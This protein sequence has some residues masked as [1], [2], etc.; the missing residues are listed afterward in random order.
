MGSN[1]VI[2][3]NGK[4]YD[5]VTGAVLGNAHVIPR[6]IMD[7]YAPVRKKRLID[8]FRRRS[9]PKPE[10][11][12]EP[13][14]AQATV[15]EPEP[16]EPAKAEAAESETV[17]KI[18]VKRK[19]KPKPARTVADH[20]K[21][22][23]PQHSKTLLRRHAPKPKFDVKPVVKR[24]RT[25][26]ELAPKQTAQIAHKRSVYS[27]DPI[28]E[29]RAI[30]TT[31]HRAVQHFKPMP[32]HSVSAQVAVLPVEIEPFPVAAAQQAIALPAK[33]HNDIF[34]K[35][36]A[37]ATSHEQ[38][39]PKVRR[40]RKR[41]L[42]HALAV[43][44]VLFVVGGFVG[45]LNL[46]GIQM[47]L[48]SMQAGF[49]ASLP[50]YA[51]TGYTLNGGVERNGDA[52]ALNFRSGDQSYRITQQPSNWNSE[53]LLDNTLGW[54]TEFQTVQKNGQ[55]IYIFSEGDIRA[56]WVNGGVRYEI[57]GN[58]HLSEYDIISIATSL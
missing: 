17:V 11:T 53:T 3:F 50:G 19:P 47:R 15:A 29:R 32:I 24:V 51:P 40:S 23:K 9:E 48:A 10:T 52:I 4:R 14:P 57:A 30:T 2:E 46:D 49:S 13:E 33:H 16:V 34:T 7:R 21:P 45:Y 8:S 36:I 35:A 55:T 54:S 28:R 31:K 41:K 58:A 18:K 37:N 12:P 25:P 43:V 27:I 6:H 20:I 56:A 38:P 22:H 42:A 39:A 44:G 5:A 26:A 1:H